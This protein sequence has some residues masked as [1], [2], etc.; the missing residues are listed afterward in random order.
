MNPRAPGV[1][2]FLAVLLGLALLLVGAW[3][4]VWVL[5]LLPDGWW[6][7]ERLTLGLAESVTSADWWTWV[8]LLGGLLLA[9]IG[10][11]WIMGHLRS[12]AVERVSMPGDTEGGR[13]LLN[14]K[15]LAEGA[16][17]ALAERSPDVTRA[18][19]RLVN[20]R[21]RIVLALTATVRPDVDL[22]EI[23]R[24]CDEVAEHASRTS[25]RDDLTVRV[26]LRTGGRGQRP[27]VH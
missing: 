10:G 13:V 21:N 6:S 5:D 22:A 7:P 24:A 14:G 27:R 9:A 11:A 23:S 19:G 3:L 2:R 8:L 1:D 4:V 12:S 20:E 25:G 26:R 16:A 15:A 18:S 17:A